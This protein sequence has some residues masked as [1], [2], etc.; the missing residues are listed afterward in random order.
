V[1]AYVA[2]QFAYQLSCLVLLVRAGIAKNGV[3]PHAWLVGAAVVI[4]GSVVVN[5]T[6]VAE[7]PMDIVLSFMMAALGFLVWRAG[8]KLDPGTHQ[9]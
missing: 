6:E 3:V 8:D 7:V 5:A 2:G 4:A 9:V 1:S